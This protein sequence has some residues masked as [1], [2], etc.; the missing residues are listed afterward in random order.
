MNVAQLIKVLEQMPLDAEVMHLWDGCAKTCIKAV[1]LAR[2]GAV[3]TA[4]TEMV[5]YDDGDR[6][7]YA[8]LAKDEPYW[9]SSAYIQ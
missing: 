8:P 1:W 2:S 4:D 5:C 9:E 3:V 7:T 6:P